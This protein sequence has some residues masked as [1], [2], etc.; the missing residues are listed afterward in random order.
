MTKTD[1]MDDWRALGL[2]LSA[3]RL[4]PTSPTSD[5]TL[6]ADWLGGFGT[7][8]RDWLCLTGPTVQ[9]RA[10]LYRDLSDGPWTVNQ[11]LTREWLRTTPVEALM[12]FAQRMSSRDEPWEW[13]SRLAALDE[14]VVEEP[15]RSM[16][17]RG[18]SLT[19]DAARLFFEWRFRVREG[20][21]KEDAVAIRNTLTDWMQGLA[22]TDAQQEVV[23]A[24]QNP[25]VGSYRQ[26]QNDTECVNTLL[27]FLTLAEQNGVIQKTVM[28]FDDL[29]SA[30]RNG[31][32][33][34]LRLLNGVLACQERW[35]SAMEIPLAVL[36][37]MD[38]HKTSLLRRMNPRLA[39][40]ISAR[41]APSAV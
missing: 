17:A 19:F 11:Q 36:V 35:A 21:S 18:T 9:E 29:E 16:A 37:G 27:F 1:F 10:A 32:R 23:S 12:G 33:H 22:L 24:S 15:L 38:A 41:L 3:P 7:D 34:R 20:A 40:Q 6:A 28:V 4:K 39:E 25:R 2:V 14:V 26:P 31:D 5:A 30:C 8:R 13:L